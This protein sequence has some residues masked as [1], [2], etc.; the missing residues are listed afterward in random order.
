MSFSAVGQVWDQ[1]S[2]AAHLDTLDLSWADS[3]CIHHTAFPDLAMRPSGWTIQHMRNLAHYY[4]TKLRWSSGPHLFTDE[5]QIF[6]LSPL[7]ARGVHAVSFNARSI[8]L[9]MLGNYD[10]ESPLTGRGKLV[11]ETT[12]AAVA[13]LLRKLAKPITS[14]A[15]KF[16]RDD[17]R[18]NKTCPGKLLTK[19]HFL[20]LVRHHAQQ[21]DRQASQADRADPIDLP[22]TTPPSLTIEA[23]LLRI[24]KH[25]GLHP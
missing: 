21:L 22:S 1:Q 24:E 14:T 15:V 17:A 19:D 7:T 8:G 4:G 2:F 10:H 11:L 20:A 12:A 5:D 18:T 3:V 25:L 9:E 6:G 23:R 13:L 16:H